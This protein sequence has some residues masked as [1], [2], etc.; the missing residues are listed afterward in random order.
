MLNY[1]QQLSVFA[2]LL[3]S[4]VLIKREIREE[5]G[6]AATSIYTSAYDSDDSI[7]SHDEEQLT[8]FCLARDFDIV[9][10][11]IKK[12]ARTKAYQGD[13]FTPQDEFPSTTIERPRTLFQQYY[14]FY[15][16]YILGAQKEKDFFTALC[17]ATSHHATLPREV[18]HLIAGYTAILEGAQ[19]TEQEPDVT[20]VD[21]VIEPL[22]RI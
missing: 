4:L 15:H 19:S 11:F 5:R 21:R 12:D 18:L 9:A 2:K 7:D 6:E 22:S 17:Y 14:S 1:P 16:N 8:S 3:D 10:A 20:Y 13:N